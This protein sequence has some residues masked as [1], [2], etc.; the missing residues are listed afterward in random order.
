MALLAASIP[1]SAHHGNTE[2]D[3][4]KTVT[5][6]GTVTDYLYINPHALILLERKNDRGE[7]DRWQGELPPPAKLGRAGWSKYTLKAG[8]SVT[9]SGN[10]ARNGAHTIWITKIVG[11]DGAELQLFED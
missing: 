3:T 7:T 5:I 8:D 6:A 2:Y 9:M 4:A 11:P 10:P 1:M